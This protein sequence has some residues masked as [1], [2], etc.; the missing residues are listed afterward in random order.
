MRPQKKFGT[1]WAGNNSRP[2][3][4]QTKVCKEVVANKNFCGII[5][6]EVSLE[7]LATGCLPG[8]KNLQ[9]PVAFVFSVA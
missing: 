3:S 1:H 9:T 7:K 4:L 8:F 2:G 5:K 6:I